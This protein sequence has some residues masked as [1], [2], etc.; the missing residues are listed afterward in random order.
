MIYYL[1]YI[2]AWL[3]YKESL[4]L[5]KGVLGDNHPLRLMSLNSVADFHDRLHDYRSALPLYEES[6]RISK[7]VLGDNHPHTIS[8]MTNLA[9]LFMKAISSPREPS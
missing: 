6:L 2:N 3:L 4:T 1:D 8:T 9:V 5:R 7:L